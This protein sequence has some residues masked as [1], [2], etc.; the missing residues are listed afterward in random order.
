MHL[1]GVDVGTTGCKA[2]VFTEDGG[3]LGSGFREYEITTDRT[4]RAEQDAE[5]VWEA[6]LEVMGEASSRAGSG[7]TGALSIS[8]QGDAVIPVDRDFRPLHP[9]VLGMDYRPEPQARACARKLGDRELFRET[10]MRPHPLNA[11]PKILWLR[12]NAP[13][14]FC[15]VWKVTTYAD[16]IMGRLG[17]GPVI[18]YTM[19]SRTMAFDLHERRWSARILD[20][21]GLSE[22]LLSPAAPSGTRVGKLDRE[23][24]ER[25]GL[26]PQTMLVTGGHDQVCA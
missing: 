15:R 4:G 2:V 26:S 18:D 12:E 21:V 25:T 16:Y 9:A 17:A 3:V 14:A 24:A 20:G 13:G 6:V 1:M 10:G 19:A 5:Q 23:V 11:L 7:E 22:E 8:V